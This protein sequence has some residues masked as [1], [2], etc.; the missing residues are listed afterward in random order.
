MLTFE[1]IYYRKICA[2]IGTVPKQDHAG[3]TIHAGRQTV[4]DYFGWDEKGQF[5]A[6]IYEEVKKARSPRSSEH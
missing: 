4:K 1:D 2:A 5:L 6:T 3:R